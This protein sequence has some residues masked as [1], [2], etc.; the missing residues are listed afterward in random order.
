MG[1]GYLY[2][3]LESMST[4]D[5]STEERVLCS[6][7]E[8]ELLHRST[9][10]RSTETSYYTVLDTVLLNRSYYTGLDTVL[11]KRSY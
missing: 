5:R 1:R 4:T 2:P 6:I 11:V 8:E 7:S 3:G 10:D 9:I